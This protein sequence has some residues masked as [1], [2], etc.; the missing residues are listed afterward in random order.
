MAYSLSTAAVAIPANR[1]VGIRNLYVLLGSISA[2]CAG[3]AYFLLTPQT[4]PGW[5]ALALSVLCVWIFLLE[6]R[7]VS[8][9]ADTLSFA[10]RPLWWL[11][12]VSVWRRQLALKDL[13]EMTSLRPWL[14]FEVVL[15]EGQFEASRLLFHSRNARLK[16]FEAVKK[17]APAV[18][19]Y[20]AR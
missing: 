3:I 16:F 20:R 15:L 9:K 11:P 6:L 13:E 4:P 18:R 5:L 12:I 14:N 8:V 2:T 10:H 19:I 7:G 17:R 1:T